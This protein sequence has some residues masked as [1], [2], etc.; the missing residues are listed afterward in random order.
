MLKLVVTS[1]LALFLASAQTE[2]MIYVGRLYLESNNGGMGAPRDI[3]L[4]AGLKPDP[5]YRQTTVIGHGGPCE[6]TLTAA[7]IPNGFY[8]RPSG[9]TDG[10]KGWSVDHPAVEVAEWD[11]QTFTVKRLRFKMNLYADAGS[12][13]IRLGGGANVLVDVFVKP[14]P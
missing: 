3:L 13:T 8:I 6:S 12:A 1:M 11:P 14:L 2:G 9:T 10:P 4:P 7:R 5:S